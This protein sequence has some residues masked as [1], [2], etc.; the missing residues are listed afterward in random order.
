MAEMTLTIDDT[1]KP[2]GLTEKDKR[3]YNRFKKMLAG[4]EPGEVFSLDYWF[5]RNGKFHRLHMT[6][7]TTLFDSQEQFED[8]YQFRK[9]LEVGAGYCDWMPGPTGKAVP[10]PKSISYRK[11][12]DEGMKEVHEKVKAFIR[13]PHA[14]QFL[15]PHL[16][17]QQQTEM[18]D[19]ILQEF[20]RP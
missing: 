16:T 18:V 7:V 13:G 8:D 19:T 10:I 9:W 12:D 11:L 17:T 6:M 3:A 15:W 1:G 2:A 14:Q 20:E 5:P 4:A